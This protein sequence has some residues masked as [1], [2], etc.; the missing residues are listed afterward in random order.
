M[1]TPFA[2]ESIDREKLTAKVAEW[3]ADNRRPLRLSAM[4]VRLWCGSPEPTGSLIS[5]L[6][7]Y[8]LSIS[9]A[10]DYHG[11]FDVV[12]AELAAKGA[13]PLLEGVC[14]I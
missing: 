6:A 12:D 13:P 1:V 3:V 2:Y 10:H 9:A 14:G 7:D 5:A 11:G 4:F 8:G